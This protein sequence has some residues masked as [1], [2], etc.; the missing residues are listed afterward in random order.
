MLDAMGSK[1]PVG[2]ETVGIVMLVKDWTALRRWA[3]G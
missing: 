3:I 1:F 2:V